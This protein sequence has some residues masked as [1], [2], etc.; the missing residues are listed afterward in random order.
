MGMQ[1]RLSLAIAV[2]TKPEILLIDE[3]MAVGDGSFQ[4]KCLQRI[5]RLK[6]E[7]T[8]IILVSHDASMVQ[9]FCTE[10]LWLHE[11]KVVAHGPAGL[12]VNQYMAD[13]GTAAQLRTGENRFGSLL[14]EIVAVRLLDLRGIPSS[15]INTGDSIR[16]EVDYLATQ[17]I[18]F[19]IFS[20][21][22][23]R[24]DGVVCCT[25]NTAAALTVPFA[26]GT[27]TVALQIERLDLGGGLYY[28]DVGAY[29][30]DWGDTYTTGTFILRIRSPEDEQCVLRPPHHWEM[31]GPHALQ[32]CWPAFT[33]L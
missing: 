25:S 1:M 22:I 24:A 11:G 29:E 20:V 13:L 17:P 31:K 30:R 27:G 33:A 3:V 32:T 15:E 26:Q 16:V 7:G 12:V 18:R 10:A 21:T 8:A 4:G 9:Q 19:P 28:V 14:L 2:H 6:A 23:T 5:T